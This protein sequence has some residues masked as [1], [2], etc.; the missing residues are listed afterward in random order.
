MLRESSIQSQN[1]QI[2]F[3]P[4][5]TQ[6]CIQDCQLIQE[7][8]KLQHAT[9]DVVSK[10]LKNSPLLRKIAFSIK[11]ATA[12]HY[13]NFLLDHNLVHLHSLLLIITE[14]TCLSDLINLVKVKH[15]Q[16]FYIEVSKQF[17]YLNKQE[18][19]KLVMNE[20]SSSFD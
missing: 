5:L 20:G 19:N 13:L 6:L 2:H 16:D 7:D 11:G 3:G 8:G 18:Y 17:S 9:F 10:S 12:K 1:G 15:V 14:Q 4:K